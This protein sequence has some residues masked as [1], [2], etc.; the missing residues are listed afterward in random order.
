MKKEGISIRSFVSLLM[1]ICFILLGLSGILLYTAPQCRVADEIGW[2]VLGL[3]KDQWS[4]VHMT[5]ALIFLV[6]AVIHLIIYNWNVFVGYLK[7]RQKRILFMRRELFY[8]LVAGVIL[9]AGAAMLFP[10][11]HLLPDYHHE[12]QMYY[13]EKS[14]IDDDNNETAKEREKRGRGEGRGQGREGRRSEIQSRGLDLDSTDPELT[15]L[16]M[17]RL[18]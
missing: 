4:S 13:R 2:R 18:S 7:P 5:M 3:A 10:P 15:S 9:L 14:G 6:L 8:S 16:F 1:T 11:F 12:I 17:T